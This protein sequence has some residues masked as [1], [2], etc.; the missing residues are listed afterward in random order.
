MNPSGPVR[1]T[2]L[3]HLNGLYARYAEM[4]DEYCALSPSICRYVSGPYPEE[5]FYCAAILQWRPSSHEFKMERLFGTKDI[6]TVETTKTGSGE[7]H[8]EICPIW[9]DFF[10][11]IRKVESMFKASAQPDLTEAS[12][13]M[14]E[15]ETKA[16]WVRKSLQ[17]ILWKPSPYPTDEVSF[18]ASQSFGSWNELCLETMSGFCHVPGTHIVHQRRHHLR[19]RRQLA[20]S[21]PASRVSGRAT[22]DMTCVSMPRK[23]VDVGLCTCRNRFSLDWRL[24]VRRHVWAGYSHRTTNMVSGTPRGSIC[25]THTLT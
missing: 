16:E 21:T 19:S 25:S 9:D 8:D 6:S 23:A 7:K 10:D 24:S 1:G 5:R 22:V 12:K 18:T 3:L 20:W 14:R 2:L 17:K 4:E 11:D 15:V 13:I